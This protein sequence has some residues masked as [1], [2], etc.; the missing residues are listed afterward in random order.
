MKF[1]DLVKAAKAKGKTVLNQ[2]IQPEDSFDTAYQS[3]LKDEGFKQTPYPD[4]GW[5]I[6]YGF[7]IAN[8]KGNLVDYASYVGKLP[9]N[10]GKHFRQWTI[11]QE[12]ARHI[13][14]QIAH[15]KLRQLK[16]IT[17]LSEKDLTPNQWARLVNWAYTTNPS[18]FRKAMLNLKKKN[19][20]EAAKEIM[21]S[22]A[23]KMY[24]S[25]PKRYGG[26]LKRWRTTVDALVGK[27]GAWKELEAELRKEGRL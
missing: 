21:D 16:Q 6:G 24:L 20:R 13:A 17:G 7:H 19:L 3:I 25:N 18:G 1:G 15:E 5:S 23:Y 9:Y 11:K 4:R 26:A 10:K 8:E 22:K 2:L 27:S 12:D 14:N